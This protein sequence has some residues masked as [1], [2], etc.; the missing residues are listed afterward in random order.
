MTW[1]ETQESDKNA[2][3][4]ETKSVMLTATST[5]NSNLGQVTT[6]EE[7]L[8]LLGNDIGEISWPACGEIVSYLLHLGVEDRNLD[9]LGDHVVANCG[10]LVLLD[11]LLA[12]LKDRGHRVL[13][14]SQ[15]IGRASC[16]E[17][18]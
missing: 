14:F 9:P 18:V 17:R 11:K 8:S 12:K 3:N 13:V 10:K 1:S 16:R 7:A 4:V 5:M 6:L 15:K 2:Y